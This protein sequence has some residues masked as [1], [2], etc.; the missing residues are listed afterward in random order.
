MGR[1]GRGGG[2]RPISDTKISRPDDL[3]VSCLSLKTVHEAYDSITRIYAVSQRQ[4]V[5]F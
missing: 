5:G 2:G 4:V 3:A 1:G